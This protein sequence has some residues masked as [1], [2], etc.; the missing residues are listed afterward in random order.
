LNT[1]TWQIDPNEKL[2]PEVEDVLID[3]AEDFVESV[4]RLAS[5]FP[6]F[7]LPKYAHFTAFVIVL[8]LIILKYACDSCSPA[9]LHYISSCNLGCMNSF[10]VLHISWPMIPFSF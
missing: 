7:S 8:T 5:C 2:D 10:P 4:S 1:Y 9:F 3:I 6:F